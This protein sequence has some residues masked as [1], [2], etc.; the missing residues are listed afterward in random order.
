MT[1]PVKNDIL[2][3]ILRDIFQSGVAVSCVTLFFDLFMPTDTGANT[4]DCRRGN[5]RR[6][7]DAYG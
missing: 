7:A 1:T 6:N 5:A 2:L 3:I 4:S